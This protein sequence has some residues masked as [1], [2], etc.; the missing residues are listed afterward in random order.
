[1]KN[2]RPFGQRWLAGKMI[3]STGPVSVRAELTGG[4]VVCRHYDQIRPCRTE[5][6]VEEQP[7][8]ELVSPPV[9][10][11]GTT[12]ESGIRQDSTTVLPPGNVSTSSELDSQLS[13]Y[14]HFN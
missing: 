12:V 7:M 3:K 10:E 4:Q 5:E 6:L 8:Q 13:T 11:S 1:M 9:G 2:F 14:E